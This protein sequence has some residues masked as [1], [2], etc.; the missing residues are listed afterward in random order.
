[1][2]GDGRGNFSPPVGHLL[3]MRH[4]LVGYEPVEIKHSSGV[5]LED[6]DIYA[7]AG[8]GIV[9]VGTENLTLSRV[10]VMPRPGA[11]RLVSTTADATHFI[12]CSGTVTLEGCHF[13][14]MGDDHLNV[15]GQYEFV[16]RR[17]DA[18]TLE[19][20]IG[21]LAGFGQWPEAWVWGWAT[22]PKSGDPLEF[23]RLPSL[24]VT[25][26][27]QVESIQYDRKTGRSRIVLIDPLPDSVKEGDQFQDA[28][29]IPALR[30]RNCYFGPNRAR[31]T[32]IT[33]RD[34]IVEGCTFDRTGGSPVFICC[35]VDWLEAP[36]PSSVVIRNNRFL[37]CGYAIANEGAAIT[38][39]FKQGGAVGG[40]M[41]NLTIEGNL[42]KGYPGAGVLAAQVDGLVFRNNRLEATRPSMTL[43]G[44]RN[45]HSEGNQQDG[46]K[47]EIQT[48]SNCEAST[49]D[50]PD[51]R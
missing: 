18:R 13:E 26:K 10:R 32:L 33:T 44:C 12:N 21:T 34:A 22:V 47:P 24:E 31:G 28:R 43:R 3:A 25:A 48:D 20:R 16:H 17:L 14:G 42:I 2:T 35:E 51:A 7:G 8:M 50:L 15:H 39:V 19:A 37:G 29:Q 41:R 38:A 6:V 36:A 11:S 5:L 9:G 46:G 40:W 27:A 4:I 23:F 49:L 45:G 1:M 30:V